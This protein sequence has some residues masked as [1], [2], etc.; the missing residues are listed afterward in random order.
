VAK[1]DKAEAKKLA[2]VIRLFSETHE[3][4]PQAKNRIFD[5]VINLNMGQ[6]PVDLATYESLEEEMYLRA[7]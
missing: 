1:S 7:E 2:D 4:P 5:T 6:D 3:V